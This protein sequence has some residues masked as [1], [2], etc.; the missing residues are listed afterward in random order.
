MMKPMRPPT[1]IEQYLAVSTAGGPTW[2]PDGNQIA[3][4]YNE[5]GVH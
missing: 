3:L 4:V 5:P 1:K 2:H